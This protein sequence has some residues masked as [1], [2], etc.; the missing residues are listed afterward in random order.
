[1][2]ENWSQIDVAQSEGRSRLVS[3]LSINPLKLISP[4]AES[5]A[6]VSAIMS[7]Y[8][9]GMLEGDCVRLR[10]N[11]EAGAG[12]YLGTQAL[13]KIYKCPSGQAAEQ[14]IVGQIAAGGFHSRPNRLHPKKVGKNKKVS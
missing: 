3:C 1:M 12:L 2:S 13:S 4:R 9:G 5:G 14:E 10:I 8:G 7:S 11:C 6:Y